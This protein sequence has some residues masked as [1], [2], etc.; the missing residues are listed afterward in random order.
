MKTLHPLKFGE[1]DTAAA[2]PVS[3]FP[4]ASFG[5]SPRAAALPQVNRLEQLET[6]LKEAQ[7]RAEI[8]EKEAYEKAYL[9][10]EKAGIVLGKKRGEQILEAL[11]E[12]LLEADNQLQAIQDAFANAAIDLAEHIAGQI[13]GSAISSTEDTAGDS[14]SQRL[15]DIAQQAAALLTSGGTLKIA[16][17]PDDIASFQRLLEDSESQMV[18]TPDASVASGS[19]RIVSATQD[20]LIDPVAAIHDFVEQLRPELTRPG[21]AAS[22]PVPDDVADA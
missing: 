13:L 18:L 14:S 10:G 7:G 20:M 8:V 9:A 1:M 19:C 3:P 5:Q 2:E 12:T 11:Q 22:T 17:C 4:F 21:Q 16:V 6:M 15:L